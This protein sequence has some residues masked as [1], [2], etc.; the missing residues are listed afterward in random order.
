MCFG[1]DGRERVI[2]DVVL[3]VGVGEKDAVCGLFAGQHFLLLMLIIA[4][5]GELVFQGLAILPEE[6]HITTDAPSSEGQLLNALLR[7]LVQTT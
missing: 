4:P 7:Q 1:R 3:D 6:G 5:K 2:G